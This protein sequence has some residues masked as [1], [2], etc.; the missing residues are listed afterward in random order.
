MLSGSKGHYRWRDANPNTNAWKSAS[1]C[2]LPHRRLSGSPFSGRLTRIAG[3]V[4]E[5]RAGPPRSGGPAGNQRIDA[6]T[7]SGPAHLIDVARL[8]LRNPGQGGCITLGELRQLLIQ[9]VFLLS[10]LLHGRLACIRKLFQFLA[11]LLFQ[12]G[13][14]PND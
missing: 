6:P 14:F 1:C 11:Y 7:C 8:Q 4:S 13:E 10:Q 2:R 3:S 12:T 5:I 9:G